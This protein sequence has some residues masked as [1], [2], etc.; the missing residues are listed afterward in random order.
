MNGRCSDFSIH[1]WKQG[2][3]KST[4][5]ERDRQKGEEKPRSCT[6]DR[7]AG[8]REAS[9]FCPHVLGSAN[10]PSFYASRE[11]GKE[12]NMPG[13][14]YLFHASVDQ[15]RNIL[16]LENGSSMREILEISLYGVS[17][18][19]VFLASIVPKALQM[20]NN[21]H[22]HPLLFGHDLVSRGMTELKMHN[23]MCGKQMTPT[24]MI[25]A[26]HH[27]AVYALCLPC[28]SY[29]S[30]VTFSC[31]ERQHF[32]QARSSLLTFSFVSKNVEYYGA[33]RLLIEDSYKIRYKKHIRPPKIQ[34]D[35]KRIINN[36]HYGASHFCRARRKD[37]SPT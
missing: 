11:E 35:R 2:L 23:Q 16:L 17:F 13:I 19:H 31:K 25:C 9:N 29:L 27:K 10:C 3:S 32:K 6:P 33:F 14:S 22:I 15:F 4:H 1:E 5:P 8:S 18:C 36:S 20:A 30:S 26:A 21:R 12:A 24:M 28:I 7:L 37:C 34:Q